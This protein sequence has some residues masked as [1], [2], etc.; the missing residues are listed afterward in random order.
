[1]SAKRRLGQLRAGLLVAVASS[2]ALGFVGVRQ[3]FG[4]EYEV[5]A[6]YDAGVAGDP[7]TPPD[8]V[9]EEGHGTRTSG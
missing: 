2:A 6:R 1:M 5:F 3:A 4:Q 8:P 9:S 7:A